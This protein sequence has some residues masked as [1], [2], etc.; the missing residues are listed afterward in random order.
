MLNCR[1]C[2]LLTRVTQA[3]E[4]GLFA[5][6][7]AVEPPSFHFHNIATS[8]TPHMDP[9]TSAI[10]VPLEITI[11]RVLR[12]IDGI[13]CARLLEV[14]CGEV[15]YLGMAIASHGHN[16]VGVDPSLVRI[17]PQEAI[18]YITLRCPN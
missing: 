16:V 1:V 7:L 13:E 10:A 17:H 6:D 3:H 18:V 2:A 14:G 11:P 4:G 9:T 5:V 8:T 12:L 15:P